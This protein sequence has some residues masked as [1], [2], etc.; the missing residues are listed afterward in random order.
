MTKKLKILIATNIFLGLAI[1]ATIA[2]NGRKI[3]FQNE[4]LPD[5]S[6]ADSANTDK[7]VFGKTVLKRQFGTSWTINDTLQADN[8]MIEQLLMMLQKTAIKRSLTDKSQTEMSVKIAQK[9]TKIE[10]FAGNTLQKSFKILGED[11]ETFAQAI[12][13]EVNLDGSLEKNS[14]Q[15]NQKP[16][17]IHTPAYKAALHEVF[18]LP[19]KEWRN[20]TLISVGWN[21]LQYLELTYPQKPEQNFSIIFDSLLYKETNQIFYKMQ[22]I[23]QLDSVMLFNYIKAFNSVRV[24]KYLENNNL[25]DSLQKI[26]PYCT[27][28]IDDLSPKQRNTL[29]LY[30]TANKMFGIVEKTNDLVLFDV[31][32]ISG[33]LVRKKDFEK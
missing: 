19:E 12:N 15:N 18:T 10:F 4:N 30:P 1:V 2:M 7:L 22:G 5:F 29:R 13:L 20:R 32:Y 23:K 33:L 6:L 31:R 3:D 25:R 26:P 8:F 9:G 16:Y 17:V 14:E 21:S 11:N 28:K 27:I 24:A